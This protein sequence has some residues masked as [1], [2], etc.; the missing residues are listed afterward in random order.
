MHEIDLWS[1]LDHD[2]DRAHAVCAVLGTDH[3]QV[4]AMFNK[5]DA[6]CE[7]AEEDNRLTAAV[8]AAD[9]AKPTHDDVRAAL[10]APVHVLE[11]ALEAAWV[12]WRSAGPRGHAADRAEADVR[13][14]RDAVRAARDKADQDF[15]PAFND[16]RDAWARHLHQ[17]SRDSYNTHVLATAAVAQARLALADAETAVRAKEREDFEARA[18]ADRAAARRAEREELKAAREAARARRA[19]IADYEARRAAMMAAEAVIA[20]PDAADPAGA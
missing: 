18:R 4:V 9:A 15:W 7:L 13:R 20:A 1:D 17:V 11:V 3:P 19:I 16:A 12:A 5:L 10:W 14:L 2:M 6:A 8:A